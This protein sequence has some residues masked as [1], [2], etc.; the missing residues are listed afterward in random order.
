MGFYLRDQGTLEPTVRPGIE[1][2]EA[3]CPL[4]E[5]ARWSLLVEAPDR[6]A[7]GGG[8]WFPVVQCQR[9]GLC[10]T[11]PRPTSRSIGQ[12]YGGDYRPHRRA[13]RQGRSSPNAWCI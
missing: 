12:F 5:H 9:C 13:R 6:N 8:L 1:W 10:Y 4:C 7:A 11:N 3:S 2:E